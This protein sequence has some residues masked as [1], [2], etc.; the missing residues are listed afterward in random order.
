MKEGMGKY[1]FF[2]RCLLAEGMGMNSWGRRD[3]GKGWGIGMGEGM[4]KKG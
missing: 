2:S 3:W 4:G 1:P